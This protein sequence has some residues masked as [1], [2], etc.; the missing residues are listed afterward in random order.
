LWAKVFDRQLD[1]IVERE[2]EETAETGLTRMAADS[3]RATF[4]QSISATAAVGYKGYGFS[5]SVSVT[6]KLSAE[7]ERTSQQS[8]TASQAHMFTETI[9]YP[10]VGKPYRLAKWRPIDR[11]E[12]KRIDG[13]LVASWD[14]MRTEE[15]VIDVFPRNVDAPERKLP[16]S[17]A[18]RRVRA[19]ARK[20]LARVG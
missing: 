17:E 4:S 5:A 18:D 10:A 1:G 9:L 11:Y 12:L 8:Q 2:T 16:I 3:V 6:G 13:S 15:E 7:S 20:Q 14:A 19:A